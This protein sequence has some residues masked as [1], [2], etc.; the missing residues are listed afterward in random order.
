MMRLIREDD[1]EAIKQ[2]AISSG[3]FPESEIGIIEKMIADYFASNIENGHVCII[4]TESEPRGVAYYEPSLATDRVWYLTMIAVDGKTQGK[5]IGSKLM[6][7]IEDAL[8]KDG[9]RLLLVETSGA[10]SFALTRNFYIKCGYEQEARI[11]DYY[12]VGEDMILFRK[13]LNTI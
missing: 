1:T 7:Y 12:G 3:L 13:V 11:R 10:D 2:L 9:Q 6:Q 4:D 8:Q 5:G